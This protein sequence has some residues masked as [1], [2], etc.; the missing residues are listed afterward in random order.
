MK[1]T[2]IKRPDPKCESVTAE[3]EVAKNGDSKQADANVK[4]SEESGLI[5]NHCCKLFKNSGSLAQHRHMG[6]Y[7]MSPLTVL[8]TSPQIF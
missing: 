8:P 7:L 2:Q 4:V 3:G 5:C 1:T 6:V